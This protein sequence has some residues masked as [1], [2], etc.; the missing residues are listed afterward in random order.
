M[1][2]KR[3]RTCTFKSKADFYYNSDWTVEKLWNEKPISLLKFYYG[4]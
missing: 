1:D 3:L 2:I 4:Q